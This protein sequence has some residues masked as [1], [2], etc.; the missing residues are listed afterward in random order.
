MLQILFKTALRNLLKNKVVSGINIF[1]LSLGLSC[2]VLAIIFAYHELTYEACHDK[3][4]RISRVYTLGK[5][6]SFEKIHETFGIAKEDL[7]K[8]CP[9]IEKIARTKATSGIV[10]KDNKPIQEK[11]I[12][13]AEESIF[14]ILSFNFTEGGIPVGPDEIALTE[15]M[16][17]KYFDSERPLGKTLKIGIRGKQKIYTITGVYKD[18]PSNTHVNVSFILPFKLAY[19][20]NMHPDEY[21]STEYGIYTLLTK[22]TDVTKLNAKIASTIDI[23]VEIENVNYYLV[24]I[25]HMHLHENITQNSKAN[26]LALLIGG[27]VALIITLFNFINSQTVLFSKRFK[28][29]GI[30][31]TVGSNQKNIIL[32]FLAESVLTTLIS[33]ILALLILYI[34]L[35]HFNSLMDTQIRFSINGPILFG[36]ISVLTLTVFLSSFYPALKS[37]KVKPISL[38]RGNSNGMLKKSGLSNM[39]VTTQFVIAILLIQFI[40]ITQKQIKH[41]FD[42]DLLKFNA[43]DVVC[44]DGWAWGDLHTVKEELLKDPSI[45]MVSWGQSLPGA[46][47]S[48]TSE[49]KNDENQEMANV[50]N[51][52]KDYLKVFDIS[53]ATGR[54]FSDDFQTDKTNGVVINK[55]AKESLGY[56]NPLGEQ[57]QI[58][59]KEYTIV[60]ITDDYIAVPP[61]MERMPLLMTE[62]GNKS[63]YLLIRV[64]PEQRKRAHTYI[65][66][67]LARANPDEPINIKYY[68]DILLEFGKS[69]QAT[70]IFISVFTII[71][72]F[73]AMLGLFALSFFISERKNK[74]V[75]IRKVCG[76]STSLVVWKLSK[77]FV[78]KLLIAF[79]ISAPLSYMGGMGFLSTFTMKIKL[80]ADIFLLGGF[81]AFIMV[82]ISTGFK[83]WIAASRN[84]V[85]A[86]RYE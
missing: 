11:D 38:I 56:E 78:R 76:A 63:N 37:M 13:L 27:I 16:V 81:L 14:D 57:V 6:G 48:M 41:M 39:L 75:G 52:E 83:I 40:I 86:L 46:G 15:R 72:I 21:W 19:D 80:T 25:K 84:P 79:I 54:F 23:P 4:D 49:W 70:G 36:I 30:K 9:E 33:F 10:F 12:L 1:G 64:H 28:E 65:E 77:G 31:K 43:E 50:L 66:S 8:A 2:A 55:L 29:I 68:N 59:G 18:F 24:P 17:R 73:N 85:E 42:Q 82:V 35:P 34:V 60:G 22:G 32:Q 3:A 74:E 61:V 71:I 67:V 44:M 53:M 20:L 58:H 7:T 62:S 47:V 26:F 69:F 45:K 51:G 5:F